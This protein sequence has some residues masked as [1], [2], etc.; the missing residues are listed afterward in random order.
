[1]LGAH[2]TQIDAQQSD[3]PYH[4]L[5]PIHRNNCLEILEFEKLK[6]DQRNGT[7]TFYPQDM[8]LYSDYTAVIWW[9]AGFL[10]GRQANNPYSAPQIATWLFSYCRANPTKSLTEAAFQLSES[11]NRK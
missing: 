5:L 10:A 7:V 2:I 11:L 8:E 4:A 1:M 6:I 3:A 9:L